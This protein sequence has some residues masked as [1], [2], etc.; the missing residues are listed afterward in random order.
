MAERAQA[1]WLF[2]LDSDDLM[3]FPNLW[4]TAEHSAFEAVSSYLDDYDA[5]WG[6]IWESWADTVY[7]R[8]QIHEI[9]SLEKF[10][11]NEPFQTCQMGHFVRKSTF[12]G[13]D[14]SLD[15]GEDV[16]YYVRMW[17]QH[18]CVKIWEPLMLNR[19]GK[20]SKGPR[21]GSGREW[22]TKAEELIRRARAEAG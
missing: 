7:H 19:R 4:E 5:I 17:K 21:S 18:R 12:A 15:V 1:E 8:P 11:E 20:H 16:D 6:N 3:V 2:F 14:E 9:D 13:F 10:L 22:T